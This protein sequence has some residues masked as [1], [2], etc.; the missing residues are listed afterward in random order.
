MNQVYDIE[1]LVGRVSYGNVN[2][3]D[4]IQLKHSISEIPNIKT[5]ITGLNDNLATQFQALEPLDELL[6][7]LEDS[8][9]EEPPISIKDGGLFKAGFNQDLDSYQSASKNGKTWLAELQ[10][11]ERQRTGIKSLKISFNKVF[12]YFIE[13]TR[14]NLQGFD[15]NAFG[16]QR[17]QTLSNAERFITDE[18]KEK[19]DIILGAEDK[20]IELEYQ[21]FVQLR[22]QVKRYTERLQRQAKIISEIDCLQSFAEIAQKYK[23]YST[24][25]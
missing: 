11:K 1:R 12:G 19:E 20:A 16:Y 13:I 22:E 15:P 10:T 23:L 14:A 7:L 25:L 24:A 4:L 6:A 18:L 5:L 9:V 17:K 3:R 2:A 21:L 8:L